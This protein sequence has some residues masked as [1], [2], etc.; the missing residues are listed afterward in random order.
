MAKN[1]EISVYF[2]T[3]TILALCHLPAIVPKLKMRCLPNNKQLLDEVEHDIMNYQNLQ[4]ATK[5]LRHLVVKFDFWAF[6]THF[7]PFP[8][9]KC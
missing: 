2:S 8:P 4:W 3:N 6:S 7:P 1:C 9:Q 5:V